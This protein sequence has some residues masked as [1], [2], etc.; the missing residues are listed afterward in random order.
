VLSACR[1]VGLAGVGVAVCIA[2]ASGS[3][4]AALNHT[5][6]ARVLFILAIAPVLAA[7]L[8]WMLLGEP[9]RRRTMFAMAMALAGVTVMGSVSPAR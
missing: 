8:A 4:I 7:A 9:V 6:V 5:T 3:F 2:V 1:S